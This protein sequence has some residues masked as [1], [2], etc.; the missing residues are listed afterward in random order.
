MLLLPSVTAPFR[1]RARPANVAPV[2]MVMLVRARMLPTNVV[3]AP[4]VAELP[5]CQKTL[6]FDAP[7]ITATDDPD[8]VVKVLPILKINEA[9]GLPCASSVSVPVNWAEL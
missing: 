9:L 8:A 3:V 6:Q 5:T 2:L 7:L 4:S 1:A